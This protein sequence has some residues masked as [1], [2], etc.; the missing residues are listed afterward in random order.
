MMKITPAAALTAAALTVAGCGSRVANNPNVIDFSRVCATALLDRNPEGEVSGLRLIL[1]DPGS[2]F[3]ITIDQ[4]NGAQID[5]VLTQQTKDQIVDFNSEAFGEG[6][7]GARIT[8]R[9]L[10][11]GRGSTESADLGTIPGSGARSTS[12]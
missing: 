6:L 11:R 3:V 2:E 9:E 7:G 5:T 8:V 1:H 10:Y 4:P 12:P